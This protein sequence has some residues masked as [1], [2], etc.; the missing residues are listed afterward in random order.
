M[1]VLTSGWS[2][3]AFVGSLAVGA[4]TAQLRWTDLGVPGLG[5]R[6]QHSMVAEGNTGNMLLFGGTADFV[7]ALG[8]FWRFDGFSW[9]QLNVPCPPARTE[10]SMVY[11]SVRARVVLFGGFTPGVGLR[12]DTWEWDGNAW[13]ERTTPG[14]VARQLHAMAYDSVRQRVVL[15]GGQ[16]EGGLALGDTWEWD[17][18]G[19]S[20]RFTSLAPPRVYLH[21]MAFDANRGRAVMVGGIGPNGDMLQTWEFDGNNWIRHNVGLNRLRAS[22]CYHEAWQRCVL[23][24]GSLS[25]SGPLGDTWVWN[26]SAWANLDLSGSGGAIRYQTSLAFDPMRVRCVM[27]GG[28]GQ[29]DR[30]RTETWA[31]DAFPAAATTFGT[32]CGTPPLTIPPN[33]EARPRIGQPAEV[34]IENAPLGFA[35]LAI[36]TAADWFG[37]FPLPI[38]FDGLGMPGCSMLHSADVHSS[39]FAPATE[40]TTATA[41]LPIPSQVSILGR[42]LYLQAWTLAPDANPAGVLLSNGLNWD[43]GD[44]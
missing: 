13:S 15:F 25:F 17:G 9:Q 32:G 6:Y 27:Y 11:D 34:D 26:G 8:D 12:A 39:W 36:G 31:L 38:A 20:P 44:R 7:P 29:P 1:N 37:G 10:F 19:W 40:P 42:R 3:I 28:I 33:F 2:R 23:H 5:S 16:M 4:L 24:G 18:T 14:P 35:F 41:V 30:V 43:F 21:A 22:M